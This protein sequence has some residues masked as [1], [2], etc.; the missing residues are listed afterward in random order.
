MEHFQM[1]IAKVKPREPGWGL[2][3][4]DVMQNKAMSTD[5]RFL[6]AMV[7]TLKEDWKFHVYWIREQ[8]GWGKDKLQ[9]VFNELITH[10]HLTRTRR[11]ITPEDA[12]EL[13]HGYKPGQFVWDYEFSL[14]PKAQPGKA[15]MENPAPQKAAPQ[16]KAN[17]KERKSIRNKS[18][19]NYMEGGR[20]ISKPQ[21]APPTTTEIGSSDSALADNIGQ[22]CGLP[23]ESPDIPPLVTLCHDLEVTAPEVPVF[24]NWWHN[25]KHRDKPMTLRPKFFREDL[26]IWKRMVKVRSRN[27]ATDRPSE[28]TAPTYDCYVIS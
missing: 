23:A 4:A 3:T 11:L 28:S 10:H 14:E 21:P 24:E 18:I 13:K 26:P 15:A 7:A 2:V 27:G 20:S 22:A 16:N 19:S 12:Y 17:Y 1:S 6:L 9:A 5:A 25:V 8:T